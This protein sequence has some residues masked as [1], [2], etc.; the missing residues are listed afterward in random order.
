MKL[1][2]ATYEAEE[3][4]FTNK[5]KIIVLFEYVDKDL[6]EEIK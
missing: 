4:L 1:L 5:Y 3:S 2:G 6:S